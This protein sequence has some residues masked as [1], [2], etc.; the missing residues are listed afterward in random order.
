MKTEQTMQNKRRVRAPWHAPGY[1]PI[2]FTEPSKT[3]QHFEG[4]S[5]IETI[6]ERFMGTGHLVDP[7]VA[8]NRTPMQGDFT[9]IPANFQDL[10]NLVIKA[11]DAFATVPAPLRAAFENDPQR[12]IQFVGDPA[13]NDECIRLG[14]KQAVKVP[15]PP[16]PT[17]VRIVADPVPASSGEGKKA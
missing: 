14:L 8:R 10:N 3:Q 15:P 4:E 17:L 9:D 1:N 12:F 6:V 16:E 5:N 7:M 2:I 11:R 13:N